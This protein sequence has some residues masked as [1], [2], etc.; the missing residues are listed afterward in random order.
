MLELGAVDCVAKVYNEGTVKA[1]TD[2]VAAGRRQDSLDDIMRADSKMQAK[3]VE[4]A[5]AFNVAAAPYGA[6]T[7]E[8]LRTAIFRTEHDNKLYAAEPEIG[9][10]EKWNNN[11]VQLLNLLAPPASMAQTPEAF[12]VWG[13]TRHQLLVCDL[14]GQETMTSYI[15]TDPQIGTQD[16]HGF[17]IGNPGQLE[18]TRSYLRWATLTARAPRD[19]AHS[20]SACSCSTPTHAGCR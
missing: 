16:G 5:E 18:S 17:G 4:L 13:W 10:F 7:V 1:H 11:G 6:K 15:F 2:A 20:R 9:N 8:Y 12:M 19:S 3:C 14:Q